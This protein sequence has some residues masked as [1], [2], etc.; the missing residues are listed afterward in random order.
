VNPSEVEP[1]FART[2]LGD[3]EGDDAWAAIFSLHSHGSREIF[4]RA[5]AW[6]LSEDA[7][8]E[9]TRRIYLVPA[10]TSF[11][12]RLLQGKR[13]IFRDDSC[14]LITK[15]LESEQDPMVLD[16]AISALGHLGYVEAIPVILRYQ[17]R[18]ERPICC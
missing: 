2:L 18:W 9:S 5:A 4:E 11:D 12:A 6:C 17:G 15:L 7:L 13:I 8:K 3:Y 1:L 10:C 14:L 16:S